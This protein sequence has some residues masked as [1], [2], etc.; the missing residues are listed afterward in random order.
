MHIEFRKKLF[1]DYRLEV[2]LENIPGP[3]RAQRY[4]DFWPDIHL[5]YK[6]GELRLEEIKTIV[7]TIYR[8]GPVKYCEAVREHVI[9]TLIKRWF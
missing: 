1:W 7:E 6:K 9:K 3:T 4:T 8:Y 2:P 5:A